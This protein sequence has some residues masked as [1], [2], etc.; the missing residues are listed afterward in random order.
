MVT[1]AQELAALQPA[2]ETPVAVVASPP[3]AKAP[4]ADVARSALSVLAIALLIAGS[5][6]TLR[7][8]VGAMIWA[9]LLVVTT[10]PVLRWF[11]ARLWNRR[12]LAVLVMS[13]LV[14]TLLMAP[15]TAAL[16]AVMQ[17]AAQLVE[18]LSVLQGRR[19]PVIAPDALASLPWLGAKLVRGWNEL[20][21]LEPEAL[22]QRLSPHISRAMSWLVARLGGLGGLVVQCL[23]TVAIAALMYA[24]GEQAAAMLQRLG[25]RLGGARGEGAVMLAGRAV[26]GVALGV[27]LTALLQAL[28]GGMGLVIAGVPFAGLWTAFMLLLC[29]AQLGPAL[30]LLPAVAWLYGHGESGWGSFLLVWALVVGTLDNVLRPLLIRRGADLPL[31]L[32]FAGVIGG[33]LGFGLVGLF[34]GPV[35]LA[36]SFTLLK[37]WLDGPDTTSAAGDA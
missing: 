37:A 34:M 26:R 9:T 10:W 1:P 22:L 5:L 21:A 6:W 24:R 28:L 12:S 16:L 15:L 8:F 25:L 19:L 3:L 31:P 20:A 30:V 13:L 4:P 17:H 27:G 2:S 29:I 14:L 23:L 36:V 35:I 33:L 32:V 11:Q 18:W 7:P